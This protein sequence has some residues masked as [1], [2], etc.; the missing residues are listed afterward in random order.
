MIRALGLLGRYRNETI[1]CIQEI[2]PLGRVKIGRPSLPRSLGSLASWEVLLGL[3][4]YQGLIIVCITV[5][6]RWL[7][8]II[9][10]IMN[11]VKLRALWSFYSRI[12]AE[13]WPS[14]RRFFGGQSWFYNSKPENYTAPLTDRRVCVGGEDKKPGWIRDEMRLTKDQRSRP[15]TCHES[16]V[17]L[18]TACNCQQDSFNPFLDC[19]RTVIWLPKDWNVL[20][21]VIWD[22]LD[23]WVIRLIRVNGLLLPVCFVYRVEYIFKERKHTAGHCK[24]KQSSQ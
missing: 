23:L 13:Q 12:E 9:L 5:L 14:L 16:S 17:L 4:V 6:T 3:S 22:W 24:K 7:I 20:T 11:R 19:C 1:L 18:R 8:A 15:F 21:K 10:I 2:V